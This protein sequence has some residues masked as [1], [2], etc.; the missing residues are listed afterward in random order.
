MNYDKTLLDKIYRLYA[1]EKIGYCSLCNQC[2]IESLKKGKQLINGPVP[3]YHIGKDYDLSEKR[4]LI[5][6]MVAYGW[7]DIISDFNQVWSQVFA[8]NQNTINE[9]QK[10]VEERV[11]EIFYKGESKYFS[12]IKYAL[13]EIYGD[14]DKA[15]NSVAITNFVH[16][17]TGSIRD[18]L[19]Q[20]ARN[21]CIDIKNNGFIHKEIELLK[22]THILGLSKNW[23]YLRFMTSS[24]WKFKSIKHP[25]APGRSKIEF[26]KEIE[27]FL[28]E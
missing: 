13:T 5:V 19:P 20:V 24:N 6:G 26:H 28:Y 18:D 4:L 12:F 8:D 16:C 1:S 2:K 3:A 23:N 25:S 15:Y 14:I 10:S 7:Q 27:Q 22:P 21:Y 17:N 11:Q 9:L